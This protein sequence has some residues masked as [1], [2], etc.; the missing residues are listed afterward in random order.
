MPTSMVFASMWSLSGASS[1][2][3]V[4]T[5]PGSSRRHTTMRRTTS[6]PSDPS[7]AVGLVMRAGGSPLWALRST[8]ELHAAW[9]DDAER[10]AVAGV[11]RDLDVHRRE[12]HR[13]LGPEI[14][15]RP[16]VARAGTSAP[17]SGTQMGNEDLRHLVGQ[18]PDDAI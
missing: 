15:E 18:A 6:G 4:R 9:H 2:P 7:M 10:V 11:Q 17:P 13:A 5:S 1:V 3:G 8:T 14:L 16:K 12:L